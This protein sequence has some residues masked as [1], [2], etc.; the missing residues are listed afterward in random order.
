MTFNVSLYFK[1]ILLNLPYTFINNFTNKI[2]NV[3]LFIQ[4]DSLFY[5][6]L[7]LKLASP[8]YLTQLSDI[9]A[10]E[11]ALPKYNAI[12]TTPINKETSTV[13]IYNFH[14]LQYCDRFFIFT[15]SSQNDT[16]SLKGLGTTNFFSVTELFP[17]ANWLEREVSE[18][19]GINFIGKQDLR[20]LL[21]QYGDSTAPFQKSFPTIGLQEMYYDPI[22]DT[23]IQN[24]ITVQI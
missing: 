9:C 8:F 13:N 23:L 20:N 3:N 2:K 10:Y 19:H 18:L 6:S 24:P 21:L 15:L 17:A 7:H 22:K 4:K 14:N 16:K 11:V 1:Y 5:L 12:A